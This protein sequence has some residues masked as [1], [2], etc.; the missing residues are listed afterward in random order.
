MKSVA[1]WKSIPYGVAELNPEIITAR[2]PAQLVRCFVR[3]CPRWL[4]PPRRGFRGDVCPIHQIRCHLSG[5]TGTYSFADPVRNII[6]GKGEFAGHILRNPFKFESHRLGSEKS[7]DALTWNVFRFLYEQNQLARVAELF[8]GE[9]HREEPQLFLWGISMDDFQP[10][11]LLIKARE[12]FEANLPVDRPLTEPDIALYLPGQYLVLIEAKFTSPNTFYEHAYRKSPASLTLDELIHIFWFREA[13]IVDPDA[14]SEAVRVPQQL[15][16]NMVFA[17]YMA[18][19]AGKS[20]RAY[21]ANLVRNSFEEQIEDEFR[22]LLR[23]E[24]TNRFRRQTWEELFAQTCLLPE[25]RELNSFM[26]NKTAGLRPAFQIA[27]CQP[28]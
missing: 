19:L 1:A 26:R 23:P 4:A 8:T 11:P 7:E 21:H 17:E 10:W 13:R 12:R 27:R 28:A 25:F 2:C 16:R 18:Q 22:R 6:V 3:G 14:A 20:T 5:N 9:R 24:F 15:W